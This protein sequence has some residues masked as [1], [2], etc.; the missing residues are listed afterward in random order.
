VES[1]NAAGVPC[2]PIYSIDEVFADPQ[3][4]HLGMAKSVEHPVLGKLDVVNN[5][6][7]LGGAGEMVYHATPERGQHTREVLKEFGYSENDIDELA[8]GG[9]I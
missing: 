3:V 2:G 1:L 7:T 9:I 4:R 6:V 8:Q 5:A